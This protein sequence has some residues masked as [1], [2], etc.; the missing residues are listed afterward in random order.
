MKMRELGRA[1]SVFILGLT[2]GESPINLIDTHVV[3]EIA[4]LATEEQD[5]DIG[6]FGTT[7]QPDGGQKCILAMTNEEFDIW[8]IITL[9]MPRI[10]SDILISTY[11]RKRGREIYMYSTTTCI[12]LETTCEWTIMRYSLRDTIWASCANLHYGNI[13]ASYTDG[14]HLYEPDRV[15]NVH[16]YYARTDQWKKVLVLP[17]IAKDSSDKIF[18]VGSESIG[19]GCV[20]KHVDYRIMAGALDRTDTPFYSLAPYS[21]PCFGLSSVKRAFHIGYAVILLDDKN[22]IYEITNGSIRCLAH[23]PYQSMIT[24]KAFF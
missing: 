9:P 12:S 15:G 20:S 1:L 8:K 18:T 13:L 6:I 17:Q 5:Y 2:N 16:R 11:S 14:V 3:R 22:D 10:W 24:A 23:W 4:H 19:S 21:G 7:A